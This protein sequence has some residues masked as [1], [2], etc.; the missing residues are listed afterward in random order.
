[1]G[2]SIH[3]LVNATNDTVKVNDTEVGAGEFAQFGDGSGGHFDFYC[4]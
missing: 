4:K 2:S 1:M 3:H